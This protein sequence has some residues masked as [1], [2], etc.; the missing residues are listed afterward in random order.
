MIGLFYL[1]ILMTWPFVLYWLYRKLKKQ[2]GWRSNLKLLTGLAVAMILPLI[3]FFGMGWY[4]NDQLCISPEQ[5][6]KIFKKIPVKKGEETPTDS[7]DIEC[8]AW[9]NAPTAYLCAIRKGK[10]FEV[11]WVEKISKVNFF[12]RKGEQEIW[13][14]RTKTLLSYY[15]NYSERQPLLFTYEFGTTTGALPCTNKG[16]FIPSFLYSDVLEIK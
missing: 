5:H 13:D 9:L 3:D 6:T 11:L 4:Y 7:Y 16:E 15:M 1:F 8:P 14:V 10:D 2:G 12:I